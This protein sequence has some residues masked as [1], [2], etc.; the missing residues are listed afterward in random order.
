MALP[1]LAVVTMSIG[2]LLGVRYPARNVRF[3]AR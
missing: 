2:F 3:V 1:R